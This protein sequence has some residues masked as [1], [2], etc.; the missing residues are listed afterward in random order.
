MSAPTPSYPSNWTGVEE[1]A[2]HL[3]GFR[4]I[5]LF[6]QGLYYLRLQLFSAASPDGDFSTVASWARPHGF[7]LPANNHRRHAGHGGGPL[8]FGAAG[9]GAC[10]DPD[11]GERE[12]SPPG[13]GTGGAQ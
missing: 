3:E 8:A 7:V 10:Y 6:H 11:A 13:P 2:V 1:V 9:G 4:N 12:L 5:D